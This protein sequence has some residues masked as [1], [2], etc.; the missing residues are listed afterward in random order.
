MWDQ[1]GVWPPAFVLASLGVSLKT[2]QPLPLQFM[3][4]TSGTSAL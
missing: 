1:S 4:V 3:W 2:A